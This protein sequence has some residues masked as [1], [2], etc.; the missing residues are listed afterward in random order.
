MEIP[1]GGSVGGTLL[2]NT[3]RDQRHIELRN[4]ETSARNTN[5]NTNIPLA[6]LALRTASSS[7]PPSS[8]VNA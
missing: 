5:T 4:I 1:Q 2:S 3:A 6:S 7:V 8:S